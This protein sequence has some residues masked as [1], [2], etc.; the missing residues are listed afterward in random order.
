[1]SQHR[2]LRGK[3]VSVKFRNVLKRNERVQ[4]MLAGEKAQPP[5]SVY[6]LPKLKVFK[7]KKTK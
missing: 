5:H 1:M 7:V 4:R 2:S 3:D 6:K